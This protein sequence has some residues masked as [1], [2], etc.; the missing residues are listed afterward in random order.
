MNEI[1]EKFKV[2]QKIKV[3]GNQGFEIGVTGIIDYPPKVPILSEDFGDNYFR[4]VKTLQ[5]EKTFIWVVFDTPQ[6]DGDGDGPYPMTEIN[7]EYL[8]II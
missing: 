1:L 5:G 8:E 2:G 7:S 6:F 3:I 4:Q